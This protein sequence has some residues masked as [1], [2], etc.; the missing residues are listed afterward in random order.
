MNISAVVLAKNNEKTIGKTL[1]SLIEFDDVVVYDNGST[2]GTIS[3]AEGFKN[4]NL[5]QGEFKGFGWTKNHATSFAKNDWIL[6]IDSDEVVDSE[7]LKELKNKKLDTKIVYKLNFKAFY[8]NIQVKH[9]G[10]NNQKIKRLYNKNV[11]SYNSNDV[12][13]DIITEGLNQELLKGNVEHYSYHS[14]SEFIIKADRYSTLFAT[15]N[16]GKKSSSPSKAFFNGMYSF[17]RTYI[18]KQGFR[19]GYVG[20]IIAFSHAVTNFYKYIKL[21]EL[22]KEL[23]K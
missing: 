21:Y 9:C 7:L 4:V 20:L 17:F 16:V 19:D 1:N 10:W 12:H 23:K 3:I 15:N 13:E 2:D 11:T 5:V 14:I 22:N 18:L 8:K 6:I